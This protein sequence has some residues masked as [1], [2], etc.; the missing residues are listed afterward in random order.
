MWWRLSISDRTG[1]GNAHVTGKLLDVR[2]FHVQ[3]RYINS[4]THEL[5]THTQTAVSLRT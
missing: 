1:A 3:K 4:H 2:R 5:P